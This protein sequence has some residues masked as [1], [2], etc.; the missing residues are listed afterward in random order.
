MS[1]WP[2]LLNIILF[3]FASFFCRGANRGCPNE[4]KFFNYMMSYCP[5]HN[6]QKAAKYPSML[7]TAGLHDPRVQYWGK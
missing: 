2:S 3:A 1:L 5:M 4:E 6:V 7:L